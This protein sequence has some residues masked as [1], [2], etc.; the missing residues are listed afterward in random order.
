MLCNVVLIVVSSFA[1]ISLMKRELVA[2]LSLLLC[3]CCCVA[4]IVL[5]LFLMVLLVGMWYVNVA[6]PGRTHLLL[7]DFFI[8]NILLICIAK[9]YKSLL[10]NFILWFRII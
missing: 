8:Q 2:L 4:V 10:F 9:K 5:C 7:V 3:T 6:F 1:I